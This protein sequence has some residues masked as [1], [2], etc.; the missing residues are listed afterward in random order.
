M[1]TDGIEHELQHFVSTREMA[2][3]LGLSVERLGRII[4]EKKL[5]KPIELFGRNRRHWYV[6]RAIDVYRKIKN[7]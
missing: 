5:L 3:S 7:G 6:E 2:K 4:R 1:L